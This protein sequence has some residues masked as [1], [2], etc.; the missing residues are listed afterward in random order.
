MEALQK[1]LE[2]KTEMYKSE[3]IEMKLAA[4]PEFYC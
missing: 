2:N 1:Y 3:E 4:K